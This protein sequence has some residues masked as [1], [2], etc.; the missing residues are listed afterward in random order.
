MRRNVAIECSMPDDAQ[1]NQGEVVT[2][3]AASLIARLVSIREKIDSSEGES[4]NGELDA[5]AAPWFD[6]A[7]QKH[8]KADSLATELGMKP[9][10]LSAMRHGDKPTPIRTLLAF[11]NHP[12]SAHAFACSYLA[13]MGLPLP[14]RRAPKVTREQLLEIALALFIE[15]PGLLRTLIHEAQDRYGAGAEDVAAALTA[16][17]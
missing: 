5:L 2:P 16:S 6:A 11:V 7:V 12:D 4:R 10:Y 9:A 8:P 3:G 13:S 1:V 14:P 15:S 17:K